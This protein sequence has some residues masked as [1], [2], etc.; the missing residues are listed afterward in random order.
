MKPSAEEIRRRLALAESIRQK[1]MSFANFL[2]YRAA[3]YRG[4]DIQAFVRLCGK[5]EEAEAL[6]TDCDGS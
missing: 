4:V 6:D 2:R 3:R 1:N 5:P